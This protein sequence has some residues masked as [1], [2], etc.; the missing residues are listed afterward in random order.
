MP[1]VS[2]PW[3]TF[4][5]QKCGGAWCGLKTCHCTV[6]HQTFTTVTGFDR[7]RTGPAG[8]RRCIT[9][10]Q[11]G[12]VL[13]GRDYPCWGIPGAERSPRDRRALA[14]RRRSA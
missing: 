3:Y 14:A 13:M 1:D 7:H 5:C 10:E 8:D 12:L 9:P 2:K 4:T 11:A 6:C